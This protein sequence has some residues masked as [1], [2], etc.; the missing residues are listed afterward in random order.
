MCPA[1][2]SVHTVHHADP[3]RDRHDQS[4]VLAQRL[5]GLP[6]SDRVPSAGLCHHGSVHLQVGRMPHE[7]Y[8]VS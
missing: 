3:C 4:A 2:P 1:A 6:V 7:Q 5:G 8:S